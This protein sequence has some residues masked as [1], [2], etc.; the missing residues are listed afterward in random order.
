MHKI[1]PSILGLFFLAS[2]CNSSP[3]EPLSFG[4]PQKGNRTELPPSSVAVLP[5]P[6]VGTALSREDRTE[7]G[8]TVAHLCAPVVAV[9]VRFPDHTQYGNGVIVSQENGVASVV[10]C[11]HVVQATASPSALLVRLFSHNF[12]RPI[13]EMFDTL[14]FDATV[15]AIEP[16]ADLALLRMNCKL[17]LAAVTPLMRQHHEETPGE[18]YTIVSTTP[19]GTLLFEDRLRPG[20][21]LGQSG[22]PV[23]QA[24]SL[25]GL[26]SGN[27]GPSGALIGTGVW[28]PS[29]DIEG[30]LSSHV[31]G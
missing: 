11:A 3:V 14:I 12:V 28:V 13:P 19:D 31:T 22:S 5:P 15:V 30:F 24:D 17:P 9:V 10:T 27:Y 21:R 2:G 7:V 18:P 1:E 6:V 4:M 23:Y 29:Q 26:A 8:H 16:Q 20:F 25:I